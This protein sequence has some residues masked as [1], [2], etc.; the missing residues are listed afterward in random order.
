M[1]CQKSGLY[2]Q[3]VCNSSRNR[4]DWSNQRFAWF[5]GPSTPKQ[6]PWGKKCSAKQIDP[7]LF[8]PLG[9]KLFFRDRTEIAWYKY[10]LSW[11]HHSF[12]PKFKKAKFSDMN[13]NVQNTSRI[14]P[15]P[16]VGT[17]GNRYFL[18]T[19]IM[20]IEYGYIKTVKTSDTTWNKY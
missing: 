13:I 8:D 14:S 2:L 7:F 19:F 20:H 10:V 1:E 6:T 4:S 12:W 18:S 11:N 3:V 16:L 17:D 5:P 9:W 15:C